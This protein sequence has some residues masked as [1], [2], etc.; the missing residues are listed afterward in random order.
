M[1]VQFASMDATCFFVSGF[2]GCATTGTGVATRVSTRLHGGVAGVCR[3]V[4]RAYFILVALQSPSPVRSAVGSR[5]LF[6]FQFVY[7]YSFS[8][9]FGAILLGE[10]FEK[11]DPHVRATCA[12]G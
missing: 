2:C 7:E 3:R 1:R 10:R 4:L 12:L 5:G 6:T 9:L 8:Y 11:R